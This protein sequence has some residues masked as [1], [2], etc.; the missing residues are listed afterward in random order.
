MPTKILLTIWRGQKS[1]HTTIGQ[2]Y[3]F[4]NPPT[5]KM[6]LKDQKLFQEEKKKKKDKDKDSPSFTLL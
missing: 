5:P 3:K 6:A 4:P 1:L 2:E